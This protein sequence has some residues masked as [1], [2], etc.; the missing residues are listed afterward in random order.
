MRRSRPG[1]VTSPPLAIRSTV[2]TPA[3]DSLARCWASLTLRRPSM[4]SDDR[5]V[6]LGLHRS[7][8]ESLGWD[9]VVSLEASRPLIGMSVRPSR[10]GKKRVLFA[11]QL[12]AAAHPKPRVR[13]SETVESRRS[14]TCGYVFFSACSRIVGLKAPFVTGVSRARHD[15]G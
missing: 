6:R 11:D 15:R 13:V 10:G 9:I 14:A 12:L 7:I 2:W 4:P 5:I 8:D 1:E 3:I